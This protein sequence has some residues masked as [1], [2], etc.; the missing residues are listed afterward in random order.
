MQEL[1]GQKT[2]KQIKAIGLISGGLDSILAAKVIKDLGI[3]V[4]GVHF[5]MPWGCGNKIKASASAKQI[6]IPLK[7]FQLDE[8]FLELVRNPQYGVGSVMNPCVD[9]KVYFLKKAAQYMKEVGA[10]FIFTGEVLG[11]RPMSQLH[12]SLNLIENESGLKGYLLRPLCAQLLKPTIPEERGWIDRTKLLSINGR[13]RRSQL[14]LAKHY[15]ITEYTPAGGG[16][17]LTEPHFAPRL[18]D[19]FKYGYRDIKEIT[20]LKWG[21]QFRINKDFKAF[22][23]RDE[24]EN[25]LLKK[26][27][28]ETDYILQLHRKNGPTLILK[29]PKPSLKILSLC[30]GLIQGFSKLKSLEPQ[31]IEY[32]QANLK[33]DKKYLT[34]SILSEQQIQALAISPV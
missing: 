9:C 2:K 10:D 31:K 3:K 28:H 25:K 20:S 34:P 22:L 23:G 17:L 26:Y 33:K 5:N 30:G 12:N 4:I 32:C 21:R 11:Q 24:E 29:G 13:G 27:A 14:D 15:H 7:T 16:C 6:G 1:F 8:E 19:A 18:K